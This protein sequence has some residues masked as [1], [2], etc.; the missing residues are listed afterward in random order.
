M[1]GKSQI[2]CLQCKHYYVTWDQAFP[3]GCRAMGFKSRMPPALKVKEASGME[4]QT[5]ARKDR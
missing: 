2:A 3:H 4:C 1:K 5:F